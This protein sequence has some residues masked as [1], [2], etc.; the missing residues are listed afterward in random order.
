MLKFSNSKKDMFQEFYT[1]NFVMAN[2]KGVQN[3]KDIFIV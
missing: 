1:M 3:E 2:N